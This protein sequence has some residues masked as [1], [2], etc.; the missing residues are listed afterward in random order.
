MKPTHVL[1][2]GS[3]GALIDFVA[4]GLWW[5]VRDRSYVCAGGCSGADK[6]LPPGDI[7]LLTGALGGI[8]VAVSMLALGS[9]LW[10]RMYRR[11]GA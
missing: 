4:S 7:A 9:L 1:V 11:N 3:V 5:T 6:D 10:R 2:A 8:L